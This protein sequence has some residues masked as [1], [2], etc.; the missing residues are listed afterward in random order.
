MAVD[1]TILNN[2]NNTIR[3]LQDSINVSIQQSIKANEQVVK[4]L[5]TEQ[6]YSGTTNKGD[7]IKPFYADS[8]IKR[9]RR[10]GQPFDRVTLKD[11]GDFYDSLNLII[12]NNAMFILAEI[13]YSFYLIF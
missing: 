2:F 4:Q 1:F 5:Q 7:D 6:L 8:T 3:Q 11:T 12:G 10:K 9:K 13:S